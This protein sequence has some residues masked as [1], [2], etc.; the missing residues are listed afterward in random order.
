METLISNRTSS[1]FSAVIFLGLL[2][3][4]SF[5]DTH[6]LNDGGGQIWMID[7]I[8]YPYPL[9][10]LVDLG[11]TPQNLLLCNSQKTRG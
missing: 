2:G 3:A 6:Q 10:R 5:F 4:E 8:G 11:L 9:E 1:F 7:I